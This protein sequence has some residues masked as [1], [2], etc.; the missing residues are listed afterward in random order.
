M[1]K[2]GY[3]LAHEA[4]L[5][6]SNEY[7]GLLD[8]DEYNLAVKHVYELIRASCLLFKNQSYA[9]SVF[10][11]ITVFEEIAKIKAGHMRSWG[12]GRKKVKR[13]KDPLFHHAQKH[14]ITIDPIYLGGDRIANSIGHNRAKEFFS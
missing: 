9:T 13:A 1:E 5:I 6:V 11:A 12:D 7:I 14:K 10:L 8:R 4:S 3:R 2:K